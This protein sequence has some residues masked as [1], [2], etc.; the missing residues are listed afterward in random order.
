LPAGGY[1]AGKFHV[2]GDH[3]YGRMIHLQFSFSRIPRSSL[4]S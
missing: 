2:V 3:E 4:E 1:A